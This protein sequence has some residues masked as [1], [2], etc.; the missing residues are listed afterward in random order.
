MIKAIFIDRDGVINKDPGGWTEYDYIIETRDFHFI[1]GALEA[2]KLLNKNEIKAIII[3][4]QAGVN[5]GYFTKEKLD[6]LNSFMLS[7]IGKK[8]GRIEK[9]YYCIH[10][11]EDR[12]NCRK[13]RTGM[14]EMAIR[15]YG[16]KPAETYFIGDSE[17]DILAGKALGMKTVFVLSGKTSMEEMRKWAVKPAYTFKDLLEAV[18][19]LL[20]KDARKYHR[21]VR[22]NTEERSA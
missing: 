15:K 18:K 16:I 1:P 19:W 10:R 5:K 17:V 21:A 4:N 12:C 7:E 6:Q 8:G 22:R 9:A 2:L 3:S 13:P 11:D 20:E 14:L